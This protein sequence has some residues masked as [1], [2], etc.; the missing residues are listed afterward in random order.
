MFNNLSEKLDKALQTL[1]GHGKITEINVAETLKEVRRALLDA[2]VNF[3]IAKEFTNRVKEKAL[4]KMTDLKDAG[5][6]KINQLLE[7]FESAKP[8]LKK[9]GFTLIELSVDVGINPVVTP[10]FKCEEVKQETI[11]QVF[12][13]IESNKIGKNILNMLI[14]A[15]QM[16]QKIK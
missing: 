11:E 3:K 9:A 2:D 1:K 8:H 4:G 7:D 16:Q 12:S 10:Y 6:E 5:S 14:K 13:E 15:S